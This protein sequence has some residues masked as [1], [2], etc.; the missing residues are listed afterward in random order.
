MDES[1]LTISGININNPLQNLCASFRTV[2][3]YVYTGIMISIE[4]R[5]IEPKGGGGGADFFIIYSLITEAHGNRKR[6]D[7]MMMNV[8]LFLGAL[9]IYIHR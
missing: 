9:Y 6:C 8:N 2:Y 1:N 4:G 7:D 5:E 3:I